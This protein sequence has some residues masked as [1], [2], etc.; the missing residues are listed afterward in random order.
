M[1]VLLGAVF[2]V[3]GLTSAPPVLAAARPTATKNPTVVA[4]SYF[5]NNTG[6][7]ELDPL[8]KGM[9]DM[10]I[11]DL[12]K[13]DSLRVVEREK[14]NQVL[15]ELRLS[16]SAFVDTK[17]AQRLGKGLAAQVILAGGFVLSENTLRIDARVFRVE[18]G[19]VLA[20][21]HVEGA[22]E[23][24]F[25]LEKELVDVLVHA[26]RLKLGAPERT[27]LR[28]NAT[29][30]YRAFVEYSAGLDA[31]DRGDRE[32]ARRRFEAALS[33]DPGYQAARNATER[34]QAVFAHQDRQ[35]TLEAD[36]E[37]A[38]LNPKAKDFVKRVE[39][40][41]LKLD[42]TNREQ[43]LRKVNLLTWLAKRD[44]L[45]CSVTR[46]PALGTAGVIINGVPAGGIISHCPQVQEV[47]HIA[48]NLV[49]DPST[50]EVIPPVCEFFVRRLP[51][52]RALA[53]YCRNVLPT[54]IE[55]IRTSLHTKSLD[56]P[57]SKALLQL[58]ADKALGVQQ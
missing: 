1:R 51:E 9:A 48:Y 58:Y 28:V 41:L 35:T 49:E 19:A 44:I 3:L 15:A 2:V 7:A 24:F 50:M 13:V 43:S 45:A 47:L 12:V 36:A 46:G 42:S 53:S 23:A 32:A 38:A 29:Q 5:D 16:K 27:R 17:S 55:R 26:L 4:V 31:S 14:L 37:F 33:A 8:A 20:S 22:K 25:A 11:G 10:V 52:D 57:L 6:N 40:L 21:D 34:L 39:N 30:S 54:E 18:T 56:A